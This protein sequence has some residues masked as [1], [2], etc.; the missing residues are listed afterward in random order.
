M[1]IEIAKGL[2]LPFL[3]TTLG[4][5]G[6]F[7]MKDRMNDNLQR[8]LSGFAAGV[9]TAAAVWS[10]ILPAIEQS[11]H[12]GKAAVMPVLVGFWAGIMFLM[13]LDRLIPHFH[14]GENQAE[15]P[16][17]SLKKT[18]MMV[19]AVALHNLPEGMAVGA[20]YAEGL[21]NHNTVAAGAFTLS[22]GIALQNFPE[23]AIISMPLRSEGMSKKKAFLFG[24]LSGVVEPVAAILT[25]LAAAAVAPVLP[26]L[27]S[28]AAGAM[29]Y[30]VVEDL[31]PEM[32][33][34]CDHWNMGAVVFSLG[35]TLMIVLDHT[36]G[37]H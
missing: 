32:N 6:V 23:G 18:T 22:L 1:Y 34:G 37:G 27:L 7:M 21:F 15:G 11:E 14:I 10:L 25:M 26:Y 19:L 36:L 13:M 30:V 35:F 17:S 12:M 8:T 31:V 28:F 33:C 9:M 2:F 5:A 20:S 3:G 29:I 4:A 24:A 16:K